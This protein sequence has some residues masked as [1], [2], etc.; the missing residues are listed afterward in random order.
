MVGSASLAD[1]LK[2]ADAHFFASEMLTLHVRIGPMGCKASGRTYY[3]ADT[4]LVFP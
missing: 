1:L 4:T 2:T 3:P